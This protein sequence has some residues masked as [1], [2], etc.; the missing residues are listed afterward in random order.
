RNLL[1]RIAD[2][3]LPA[4]S[5][6]HAHHQNVVHQIQHFI[7]HANR[8]RRIDHNSGFASMI[9]NQVQRPVQMPASLLMHQ[10]PRRARLRKRRNEFIRILNHEVSVK[11]RFGNRFSQRRHHGRPN[12]DVRHKM[13]VHYVQMQQRAAALERLFRI[14]RQIRKICR[15]YGWR[16]FYCASHNPSLFLSIADSC[17]FSPVSHSMRYA[18]PKA[19]IS[20]A[21]P[22]AA[23]YFPPRVPARTLRS[24]PVPAL[25]AALPSPELRRAHFH[26]TFCNL[27]VTSEFFSAPHSPH[28]TPPEFP[29]L[30]L[31]PFPNRA[32]SRAFPHAA[33]PPADPAPV[34]RNFP[35]F[36]ARESVAAESAPAL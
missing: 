29:T 14:S 34:S 3:F 21:A 4:E 11:N 16:K 17:L 31:F 18:A 20:T 13:S 9:L 6:I 23:C 32:R 19:P 35:S 26:R 7:Q 36:P 8:R 25:P 2:E 15:Q 12:R 27:R 28:Q 10:N 30:P 5:R 22:S 24:T 33:A 1:Q